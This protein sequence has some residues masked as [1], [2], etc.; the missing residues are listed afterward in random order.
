MNWVFQYNP[1]RWDQ[2]TATASTDWWAMNQ[3]R[4]SVSVGDRIYFWRSGSNA[5]LT[6]IGHVSSP[7]Y[8]DA[9]NFGKFKV[10]VLYD[11]FV[12]PELR[13]DEVRSDLTLSEVAVFQGWQG[14]NFRLSDEQARALDVLLSGRLK[15]RSNGAGRTYENVHDLGEAISKSNLKVK[16]E[17]RALVQ[18]MDPRAQAASMWGDEPG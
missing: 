18:S 14:T 10:D 15:P 8:E 4:E 3:N 6:A 7:V 5:S 11:A 9:S 12:E 16:A 2:L 17:L 1:R 13:R